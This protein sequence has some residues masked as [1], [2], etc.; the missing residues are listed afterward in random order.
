SWSRWTMSSRSRCPAEL[1]TAA[2]A[3]AA[4]RATIE[5]RGLPSVV[6]MERA[7]LAVAQQV[8]ARWNGKEPVWV[9]V[10]PGNNGGDGLAVARMLQS[11]G[12]PA[13]VVLSGPLKG[14]LLT[15]LGW[16]RAV[17]VEVHETKPSAPSAAVV[18]DALLGTGA[19]GHPR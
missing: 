1:W 12:I 2:Q 17:G 9:L 7:S 10:G 14:P 5:L 16:A 6:L 18:V 3:A 13:E 11:W 19:S 8:R 4:D 15:Q